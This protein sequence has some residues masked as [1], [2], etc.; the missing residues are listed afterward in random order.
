MTDQPTF[1]LLDEPWIPVRT[2]AGG[3]IEVSLSDALL[4]ARD[5]TALAET[6]PP[7]LIALYRLLLAALHRALTTRHGQWRDVD[8]ARWFRD[9]LPEAPIRAYLEHWRERFWLFHPSAPFMQVAALAEAEETREKLK[10]RTQ[11]ALEGAN[12]NTPVVF[13]HSQD[14]APSAVSFALACRNLLGFLQFTPGGLVK[15]MRD[16][17]K[18]GALANTAAVMPTGAN[19]SETLMLGLHPFDARRLDDLPSWERPL[20]T[21]AMLR[22]DPTL[23][24]GPNDRYTRLSRAVLLSPD[25]NDAG[26]ANQ[27]RQLRFAAGL[28]LGDDPNAPDPMACYR[29]NKEGKAIRISFSEGRAIWRDLPSLVPDPSKSSD[30]PAAILGWAA[31]L[32]S[33]LGQWDTPI[34]IVT[35]GLASN[36]AKLLRW[37]A[38][39]IELPQALLTQTDAALLLRQ[40]VRLAE[41]LYA[42]LR[43]LLAKMIAASMPFSGDKTRSKSSQDKRSIEEK[44]IDASATEAVF[45][46][47]A[48]RALPGLMQ[49]IAAGDFDGADRDWKA[50]LAEAAKQSW[51]A[52]R[53]SLGD[54]PAVLRADA[55]TWPRFSGLMNTL[56]PP[57][58]AATT[59]PEEV[60]A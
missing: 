41:S 17:D 53:R 19:L 24:S 12:G 13:D 8:R 36:Q 30:I 45:F 5:Y 54:S 1:N 27:V 10:A 3:V 29:I 57:A 55:R 34:Q 20:P 46:S 18:A 7:N 25:S 9:G 28:A 23:A 47:A 26:A 51:T 35:A 32:Y 59:T 38:E 49:Q 22:A 43:S 11:V 44:Y 39:R 15:T 60:P 33:T 31:N 16:S 14:E 21:I 48:E 4:N 50:T 40:Q 42:R 52:T 37:R 58:P 2:H 56:I 6:S